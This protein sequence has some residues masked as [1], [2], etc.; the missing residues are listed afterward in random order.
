MAPSDG[1]DNFRGT[2]RRPTTRSQTR[3]DARDESSESEDDNMECEDG[4]NRRTTRSQTA[5]KNENS[6]EI[7]WR[8]QEDQRWL[9]DFQSSDSEDDD[10][11]RSIEDNESDSTNNMD[12]D[13]AESSVIIGESTWGG[14]RSLQHQQLA[15]PTKTRRSSSSQ[16]P[17]PRP[18]KLQRRRKEDSGA[19]DNEGCP[20]GDHSFARKRG[21]S[22]RNEWAFRCE[23]PCCRKQ[24]EPFETSIIGVSMR[25]PVS[26]KFEKKGNNKP[27]WICASHCP[28][29][30]PKLSKAKPSRPSQE[31]EETEE[32][33]EE[34]DT[35]PVA[36]VLP[37]DLV[38]RL[39]KRT[40]FDV[41][42][43]NSYMRELSRY[44]LQVHKQSNPGLHLSQEKRLKR[45]LSRA[46]FDKGL[47]EERGIH[48]RSDPE[49]GHAEDVRLRDGTL[50][51]VFPQK[52]RMS[53]YRQKCALDF[54]DIQ[55]EPEM[56]IIIGA[57][58]PDDSGQL[59]LNDQDKHFY[60][61]FDHA[62]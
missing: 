38:L 9:R 14:T 32:E 37:P 5:N 50:I 1:E 51:K 43:K 17:P 61:C 19:N 34:S 31:E 53:K 13:T 22:V 39:M 40:I 55:F 10:Q 2:K 26:G 30:R 29:T 35:A 8:Q 18:R 4:F 23:L 12:M 27:F 56:T 28:F 62:N 57:M 15:T 42:N 21:R 41:I 60:V 46:C 58:L 44:Q 52:K 54:C 36:P 11:T 16:A 49:H 45:N 20:C 48:S 47:K 6:Q 3:N 59:R 7:P 33:E 24:F 25:N